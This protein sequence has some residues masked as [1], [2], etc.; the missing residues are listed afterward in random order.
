MVMRVA[1]TYLPLTLS[2]ASLTDQE[3]RALCDQY[4]DYLVEFDASEGEIRIMPPTDPLTGVRNS[5]LT[6]QLRNWARASGHGAVTDSSAGFLLP[7]GSRLAPDAAWLSLPRL[8]ERPTCPEFVIEL[9][10]PTD[11]KKKVHAKMLE[12]IANGVE[13]AWM[14]DPADRTVAIYRPGQAEPDIRAGLASI[15]GEGP[16]DGFV[17]DLTHVWT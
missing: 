10:S 4:D 15:A 3:F 11:R 13:L 16:V 5:E 7:D 9:L 8:T 14:I 2:A 12:W 1:E 17:L 6:A